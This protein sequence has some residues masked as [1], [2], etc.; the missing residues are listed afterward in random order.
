MPVTA[1]PDLVGAVVAHLRASADITALTSTRIS[2]RRQDSW[3]LPGYAIVVHGPTGGRGE[4]GS[5]L[6]G[7][8]LDIWC[9]GPDDRTAKLLD[10][11]VRAYLVPPD[12][13]RSVS[14]RQASTRVHSVALEAGPIFL[15]DPA[16]KWPYVVTPV[17][18]VYSSVPV[19]S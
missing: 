7:E 19:G 10:R 1:L 8:R 5:G 16:T 4:L 13:S 17:Q 14:F 11:T 3:S 18:F 9:Y 15:V 12:R 2:A 6:Y